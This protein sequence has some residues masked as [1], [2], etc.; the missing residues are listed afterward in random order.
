MN[1]SHPSTVGLAKPGS[2]SA[3][4]REKEKGIEIEA[5]PKTEKRIQPP[6]FRHK[7]TLKLTGG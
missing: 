6:I 1:E 5:H 3:Q 2:G 4:A 7:L